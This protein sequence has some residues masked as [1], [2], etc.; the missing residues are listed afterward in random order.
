[1]NPLNAFPGLLAVTMLIP[2]QSTP[3]PVKQ[4]RASYHFRM[5]HANIQIGD[6][7]YERISTATDRRTLLTISETVEGVTLNAVFDTTTKN[8]GTPEKKQ[9][10]GLLGQRPFSSTA[11]FTDA[12]VDFTLQDVKGET[13]KAII[14]RPPDAVI[15]D[16]SEA[17]FDGVIPKKGDSVAFTNFDVQHGTWEL[18]TTTYVGDEVTKIG[19]KTMPTHHVHVKSVSGEIDMFLDDSADIVAMD[20]L[21]SLRL[22]RAD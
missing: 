2:G 19:T 11:L 17:W 1:M 18:T 8:D 21:G 14:K 16:A 4:A 15:A 9:F 10:H 7:S 22:E 12:G 6:A 3:P 5:L 20:Q 13:Q